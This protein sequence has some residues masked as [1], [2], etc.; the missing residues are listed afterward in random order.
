MSKITKDLALSEER[1]LFVLAEADLS[2][3]DP[4]RYNLRASGVDDRH[5]EDLTRR[6]RAS[7]LLGG[8]FL[9]HPLRHAL[10]DMDG[11]DGLVD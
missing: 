10:F 1:K 11:G 2:H 9:D 8:S 6:R 3:S 4:G 5:A 7:V